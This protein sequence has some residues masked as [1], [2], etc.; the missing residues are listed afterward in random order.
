MYLTD[1]RNGCTSAKEFS[2]PRFF[3]KLAQGI[4]SLNRP[5]PTTRRERRP[6]L[7]LEELETRQLL[8]SYYPSDPCLPVLQSA[9]SAELTRIP[10]HGL[11]GA[12]AA[13]SAELIIVP[14]LHPPQIINHPTSPIQPI[15]RTTAL[16]GSDYYQQNIPLSSITVHA[17]D[18]ISAEVSLVPGT[19]HTF[20][21]SAGVSSSSFTLT[22]GPLPAGNYSKPVRDSSGDL[23]VLNFSSGNVYELP[24][25][26]GSNWT[27][28]GSGMSNIVAANGHIYALS[29]ANHEVYEYQGSPNSTARLQMTHLRRCFL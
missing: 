28:V 2:M 22:Y 11:Q 1:P 27:Q 4:R 25:G 21:P 14:P 5:R 12:N 13:S 16:K 23:F 15:P 6:V 7:R 8:S 17:G 18:T 19:S 3:S 26:A 20:L 9:H 24:P 10:V 29:S